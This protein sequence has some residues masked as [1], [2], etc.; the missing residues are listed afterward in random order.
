MA[1]TR[2]RTLQRLPGLSGMEAGL[3]G[4]TVTVAGTGSAFLSWNQGAEGSFIRRAA[5]A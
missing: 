2:Q 1:L 3:G 5:A 4:Q